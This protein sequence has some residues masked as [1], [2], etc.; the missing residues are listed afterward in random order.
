MNTEKYTVPLKPYNIWNCDVCKEEKSVVDSCHL[1]IEIPSL[2][3]PSNKVCSKCVG[4]VTAFKEE[5]K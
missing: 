3:P 1:V 2:K 5:M 4:Y